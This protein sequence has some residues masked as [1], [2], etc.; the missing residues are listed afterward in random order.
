MARAQGQIATHIHNFRIEFDFCWLLAADTCV[1][2]TRA[3]PRC[4]VECIWCRST[5]GT[6]HTN[7]RAHAASAWLHQLNKLNK[8][9]THD[10][11]PFPFD[12]CVTRT[13]PTS[14]PANRPN[15]L[16]TLWKGNDNSFENVH[17]R[18]RR[19]GAK[20][21]FLNSISWNSDSLIGI[22]ASRTAV[23]HSNSGKIIVCFYSERE[24]EST[25][26]NA[27][28]RIYYFVE[29]TKVCV[30]CS[31]LWVLGTLNACGNGTRNVWCALVAARKTNKM[32]NTRNTQR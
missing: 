11:Y 25:E 24:R 32:V 7:W 6:E 5:C 17:R 14:Q 26:R 22:Q 31:L 19:R 23:H 2:C 15:Q 21:K 10:S 16:C 12:S 18:R 27:F 13:H 28:S 9:Y 4:L 8:T 1:L 20:P 3:H 30:R 29:S